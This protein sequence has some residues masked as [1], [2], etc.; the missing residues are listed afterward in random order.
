MVVKGVLVV[1]V[2]ALSVMFAVTGGLV[3]LVRGSDEASRRLLALFGLFAVTLALGSYSG[4]KGGTLPVIAVDLTALGTGYALAAL[5]SVFPYRAPPD[6]WRARFL[7][8]VFK[9]GLVP[10]W[11]LIFAGHLAPALLFD[12][13]IFFLGIYFAAAMAA[14]IVGLVWAARSKPSSVRPG[15][16]EVLLVTFG[17]GLGPLVFGSFVPRLLNITESHVAPELAIPFMLILP[18]GVA[19]A[20][21]RYQSYS[22]RRVAEPALV[23][24]TTFFVNFVVGS[25]AFSYIAESLPAADG[26]PVGGLAVLAGAVVGGVGAVM[27]GLLTSGRRDLARGEAS[28]VRK[29]MLEALHDGPVQTATALSLVTQDDPQLGSPRAT[30]LVHRLVSQLRMIV[31]LGD[32]ATVG[33]GPVDL[34]SAM[35]RLTSELSKLSPVEILITESNTD[36]RIRVSTTVSREMYIVGQQALANMVRHSEATESAVS[37]EFGERNVLLAVEDDGFGFDELDWDARPDYYKLHEMQW[38]MRQI[39]GTVALTTGPNGGTRL[40]ARAPYEGF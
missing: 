11:G 13:A 12:V 7:V 24:V 20:L 26:A 10:V 6:A 36:R 28:D 14:S 37:L 22:L 4:T 1:I 16:V 39:R 17:L 34:L 30:D 25:I 31:R 40:E 27:A 23:P 38:R 35:K 29:A 9:F 19:Y 3:F 18:V 5:V 33:D 32:G 8:P 21:L 15:Q 2:P